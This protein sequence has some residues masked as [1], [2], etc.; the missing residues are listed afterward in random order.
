MVVHPLGG[1][2]AGAQLGKEGGA[3]GCLF[4][5]RGG[6]HPSND[7]GRA[8]QL[9]HRPDAFGDEQ[10]LPFAGLPAT[11]VAGEGQKTHVRR[12]RERGA[13]YGERRKSR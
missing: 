10:L 8:R 11:E 3:P 1:D 5:L 2:P 13:V 9:L 4:Q 12:E 7:E 6:E